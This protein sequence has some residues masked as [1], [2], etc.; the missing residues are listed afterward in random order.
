MSYESPVTISE[1]M[2]DMIAQIEKQREDQ[3]VAH[4]AEHIRI[5]VDKEELK[6]ALLNDRHQYEA[7]YSD[8]RMRGFNEGKDSAILSLERYRR[9]ESEELEESPKVDSHAE[10]WDNIGS[11]DVRG[12]V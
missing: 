9:D 7:G 10:Y 4:I 8:G 6:K 3:I 12:D 5:E 2:N 1:S 11:T